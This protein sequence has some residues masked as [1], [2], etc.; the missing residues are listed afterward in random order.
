MHTLPRPHPAPKTAP[1]LLSPSV[2]LALI[3]AGVLPAT[4][5]LGGPGVVPTNPAAPAPANPA[6]P[7]P[8]SGQ[9]EVT[10]RLR[11]PLTALLGT[12]QSVDHAGVSLRSSTGELLVI[13]LDRVISIEADPAADRSP[14]TPL[15]A[16][17]DGLWRARTRLERGDLDSAERLLDNL[18]RAWRAEGIRP[19]G[20]TGSILFE[21]Q[22]RARL[23]RGW[24][25]GAVWAW[26]DWV[27]VTRQARVD[28]AARWIGAAY[29]LPEIFDPGSSAC[30][31]LPPI[32]STRLNARSLRA[33]ADSPEWD[34]FA[35]GDPVARDL[36]L[37]HRF[38][39]RYELALMIDEATAS[40]LTLPRPATTHPAVELASDILAA[41]TGSPDARRDARIRLERRI[42]NLLLAQGRSAESAPT[43][44]SGNAPSA[45]TP[46]D[47]LLPGSSELAQLA[48][49]WEEAWC[50][51]AIGRSLL[52]EPDIR[53]RRTGLVSMLHVPARFAD[54]LPA[55]SALVLTEV[56]A[57]LALM[58]DDAGAARI[59]IELEQLG[60]RLPADDSPPPNPGPDAASPST[61]S[62]DPANLEPSTDPAAPGGTSP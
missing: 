27:G 28:A 40:G 10:L 33:F 16:Y 5:Q 9:R 22:V 29:A 47:S 39:A 26:L 52:R 32:Y 41:R 13:S 21:G 20:P 4:A 53:D 60:W 45:V 19:A 35:D 11:P 55:L 61:A 50:R 15:A 12:L 6:V 24:T 3:L 1:H 48:P 59:R 14:L 54:Q 18:A 30:V 37:L 17:A 43:A 44:P 34:R 56:A 49:Q 57:E 31:A 36:A 58:G 46:S 62:P 2:A 7:A 8:L 51:V 38:A 25:A 42:G 23:E